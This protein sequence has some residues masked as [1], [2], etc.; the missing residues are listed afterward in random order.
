LPI[1]VLVIDD[2]RY[3]RELMD[4]HLSNAGYQV[5][6]AEDAVVAGHLLVRQR[7]DVILLDMEMPFMSGLELL[8][9]L[10]TDA[11]LSAIPVLMVSSREDCEDDAKQLGAA[12]FL[13]KPVLSETLLA[14]IAKHVQHGRLAI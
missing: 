3:M 8:Q 1:T 7:P 4:L 11:H 14:A 5:L 6:L 13:K 10:K 2:D 9:A 12:A